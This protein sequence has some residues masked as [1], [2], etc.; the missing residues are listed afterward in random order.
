MYR[1]YS[2]SI[3]QAQLKMVDLT[4]KYQELIVCKTGV[5]ENVQIAEMKY[6]EI[7]NMHDARKKIL[8]ESTAIALKNEQR[9]LTV[10]M[11]L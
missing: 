2:L 9:K 5:E 1:V 3:E 10:S 11:F 6:N 8:I 4:N 7:V